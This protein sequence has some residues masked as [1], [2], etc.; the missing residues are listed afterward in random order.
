IEFVFSVVLDR[1][2]LGLNKG[3]VAMIVTN[4]GMRICNLIDV[5]CERGATILDARGGY[6]GTKKDVVMVA[7]TRR[8]ICSLSQAVKLEDPEAFTIILDSKE[9]HGEGFKVTTI[10]G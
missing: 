1:I 9:V 7:G 8:D 6:N 5:I 2:M 4:D 10:A 3:N